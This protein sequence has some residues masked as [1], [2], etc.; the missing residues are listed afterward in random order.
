MLIMP[1]SPSRSVFKVKSNP[2][3]SLTVPRLTLFRSLEMSIP[4][5][6]MTPVREV[7]DR[8][9]VVPILTVELFWIGDPSAL[10]LGAIN[11][12]TPCSDILVSSTVSGTVKENLARL[13]ISLERG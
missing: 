13:I 9:S 1:Q 10:Y 2:S 6:G 7:S 8:A 5:T 4:S 12:K 3:S 11:S